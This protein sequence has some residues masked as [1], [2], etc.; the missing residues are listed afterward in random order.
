VLRS[1]AYHGL[2]CYA[3]AALIELRLRYNGINNGMIGLGVREL[4]DA[5]HCSLDT[6]RRALT[7]LDDAKLAHPIT[8]GHWKGKRATE[9]RLTFYRCDKTGELPVLN[10]KPRQAYGERD[11]KVR[12][13]GTQGP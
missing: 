3:R 13:R 4:A 10:W 2:S 1:E 11:T 9:W 5:L 8:G 12:A 6:A 7:E